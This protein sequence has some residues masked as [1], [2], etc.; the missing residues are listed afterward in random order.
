MAK[1]KEIIRAFLPL[2]VLLIIGVPLTIRE[3]RKQEAEKEERRRQREIESQVEYF[4]KP[5]V[6]N[7]NNIQ[8][9][10]QFEDA[11]VWVDEYDGE[12]RFYNMYDTKEEGMR[13]FDSLFVE[14]CKHHCCSVDSYRFTNEYNRVFHCS[15][16]ET[17]VTLRY[18]GV[19][20]IEVEVCYD[21]Q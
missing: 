19:F 17:A 21:I 15:N 4:H 2:L 1:I 14:L 7:E 11:S 16:E 8:V 9:G 13:V 6:K 10:R 3:L 12:L 5:L 18:D 20:A